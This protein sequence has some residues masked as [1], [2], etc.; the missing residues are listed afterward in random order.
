MF[1]FSKEQGMFVLLFWISVHSCIR[2]WNILPSNLLGKPG[3]HCEIACLRLFNVFV[4]AISSKIAKLWLHQ[5]FQHIPSPIHC[6]H[7]CRLLASHC[8]IVCSILVKGVCFWISV[9]SCSRM[10]NILNS[11]LLGKPRIHCEIA[12]LRLLNVLVVAISRKFAITIAQIIAT[13]TIND[14]LFAFV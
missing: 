8:W 2:V 1:I 13:Y 11:N 7:S 12:C 9:H 14:S 4:E 10:R 6:S 3:I 5:E